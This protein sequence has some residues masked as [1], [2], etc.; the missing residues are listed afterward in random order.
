MV[1]GDRTLDTVLDSESKLRD[2]PA[3]QSLANIFN[4]WM[5]ETCHRPLNQS[6]WKLGLF[7]SFKQT[8]LKFLCTSLF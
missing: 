3:L 2:P 5:P 6:I 7:Q 4:M 1:L 8:P